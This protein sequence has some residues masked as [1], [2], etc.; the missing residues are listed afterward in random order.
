VGAT[1]AACMAELGHEVIGVDVDAGKRARLA[2]DEVPFFEPGLEDVLQSNIDAS[3]LRFTL[4]CGQAADFADV[5]FIAGG[6]P[7]GTDRAMAM[8]RAKGLFV[9]ESAS[10]GRTAG[11]GVVSV[12]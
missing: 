4:S 7:A 11:Q 2:A 8:S 9:N 1:H 10:V 12:S 3:Q 5:H 6:H